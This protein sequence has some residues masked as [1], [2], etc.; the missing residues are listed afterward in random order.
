M[1][2][3]SDAGF[4]I[5]LHSVVSP[6]N[7]DSLIELARYIN[8]R[9]DINIVRWKFFQYMGFGNEKVDEAFSIS[10]EK[11]WE[12]KPLIEKEVS[13]R[14]IEI[15]FKSVEK[16]EQTLF[17]LLPDGT[18]EYCEKQNGGI[19]RKRSKKLFEYN[20]WDELFEDCP[21]DRSVFERFHKYGD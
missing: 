5:K 13:N 11:Y 18:F 8:K 2:M 16:Q 12:L 20:S 4:E 10:D 19:V 9:T 15:G 6:V 3:L 14:D 17:D 1:K 21:I 7:W